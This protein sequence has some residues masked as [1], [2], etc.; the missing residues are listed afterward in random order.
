[1]DQLALIRATAARFAQDLRARFHEVLF[2]AAPAI[3][4]V[5]TDLSAPVIETP[6]LITPASPRKIAVPEKL[7]TPAPPPSPIMQAVEGS[8]V[9]EKYR[10][11][12]TIRPEFA[13]R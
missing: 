5:T 13:N 1:M 6:P 10:N 2:A 12:G 11:S 9:R 3:E 8:T 7:T 4:P